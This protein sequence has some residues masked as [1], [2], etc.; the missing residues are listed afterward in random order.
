[1]ARAFNGLKARRL[2]MYSL[3]KGDETKME[4]MQYGLAS[5]TMVLSAMI[6]LFVAVP[7]KAQQT[8]QEVDAVNLLCS[9]PSL[10]SGEPPSCFCDGVPVETLELSC[11]MNFG[12]PTS[13]LVGEGE[14]PECW[15]RG[16]AAGGG[17]T[18]GGGNGGGSGSVG[19]GLGGVD[20]CSAFFVCP[21]GTSMAVDAG[22]C[23]C[24]QIMQP[25]IRE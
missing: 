25:A 19:G 5:I 6:V 7:L 16:K 18:G 23:A 15:C 1:M 9:D 3:F 8:C 4:R 17:G 11:A 21:S 24:E 2:I 12:C 20:V 13:D 22:Q 10:I 14:W